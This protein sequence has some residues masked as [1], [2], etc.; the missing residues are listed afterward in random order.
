MYVV[1]TWHSYASDME[2]IHMGCIHMGCIHMGCIHM[3]CIHMCITNISVTWLLPQLY[4]GWCR[5]Y[6]QVRTYA[7]EGVLIG[8]WVSCMSASVWLVLQ[9][10]ASMYVINTWNTFPCYMGCIHMC[11]IN[12]FVDWLLPQLWARM[13]VVHTYTCDMRRIP[14]CVM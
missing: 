7:T 10:W 2:C 14:M 8:I 13:Y 3:G 12:I 4:A 9:L 1:N 5:S 6:G 11:I